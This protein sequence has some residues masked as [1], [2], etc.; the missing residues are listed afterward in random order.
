MSEE[1]GRLF[2]GPVSG[3]EQ[4]NVVEL[5]GARRG[6]PDGVKGPLKDGARKDV[7]PLLSGGEARLGHRGRREDIV[8]HALDEVAVGARVFEALAVAV[9]EG[10]SV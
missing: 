6:R 8:E 5:E 7:G 2:A 10:E 3:V 4:L 9:G 1:L